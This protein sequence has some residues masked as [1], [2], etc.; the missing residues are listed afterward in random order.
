MAFHYRDGELVQREED[1]DFDGIYDIRS[2][3]LNG[4]L[5]RKEVRGEIPSSEENSPALE[6]TPGT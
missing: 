3:F 2:F 5:L 6:R 1:P 4:K